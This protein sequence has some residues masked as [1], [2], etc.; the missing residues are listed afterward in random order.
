MFGA[1]VGGLSGEGTGQTTY[2]WGG[3]QH[4]PLFYRGGTLADRYE[5]TVRSQ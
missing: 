2:L 5:Y 1:S 4:L 3:A